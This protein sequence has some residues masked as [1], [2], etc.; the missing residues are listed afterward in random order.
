[1]SQVT[2]NSTLDLSDI[3]LTDIDK[4]DIEIFNVN[5]SAAVPEGSAS[6]WSCG[7]NASCSCSIYG[8]DPTNGIS[9]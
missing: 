2:Q 4:F 7:S 3:D 8:P 9:N 1:M 6:T 5:D